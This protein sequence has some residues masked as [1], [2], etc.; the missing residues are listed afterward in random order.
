MEPDE[1]PLKY[2]LDEA[3]HTQEGPV[4]EEYSVPDGKLFLFIN[5][6]FRCTKRTYVKITALYSFTNSF[7]T[8][9]RLKSFYI[10]Y[11]YVSSG[12]SG[13]SG[14]NNYYIVLSLFI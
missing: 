1:S 9:Y 7:E 6:L 12:N 5:S 4:V 11:K 3:K 13:N 2:Y 14:K 10:L 8:I